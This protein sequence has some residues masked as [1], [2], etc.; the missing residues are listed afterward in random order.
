MRRKSISGEGKKLSIRKA[1]NGPEK[2]QVSAALHTKNPPALWC[3]HKRL[4]YRQMVDLNSQTD[5][6]TH[7]F[8]ERQGK[9]EVD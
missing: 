3:I 2:L 7:D 4:G 8:Y 6:D 5:W 1:F 9:D